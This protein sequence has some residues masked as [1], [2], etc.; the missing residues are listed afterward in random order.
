MNYYRANYS[1]ISLTLIYYS[2]YVNIQMIAYY[3]ACICIVSYNTFR[4]SIIMRC[5]MTYYLFFL[6]QCDMMPPCTYNLETCE[7]L[8]RATLA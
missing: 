7:V 1:Y 3:S 2:S 6:V 4:E 8:S 5:G